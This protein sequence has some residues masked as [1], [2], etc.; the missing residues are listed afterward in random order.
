MRWAGILRNNTL[1]RI[2]LT[3]ERLFAN[4]IIQFGD[5]YDHMK[6]IA[7]N[8]IDTVLTDP[9]YGMDFQSKR[10]KNGPRYEKIV[11]DDK[12]DPL[13]LKQAYRVTK[14]GG[15]LIM[16]CD[17][18]TSDEWK[19]HIE[20]CGYVMKSQVIWNRMHHGTGDLHGSFAP[21]HDIIWYATKGRRIFY[22]S[23][24]YDTRPKSVLSHKRPSPS[25][26]NGHPTCKPV[27]LL[28]ELIK[29]TDDGSDGVILDP[30]LGSG[31]TAVACIKERKRFIGI[32]IDKKYHDIAVKRTIAEYKELGDGLWSKL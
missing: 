29:G 6:P 14:L 21:M 28:R 4:N 23:S 8:T 25:E 2:S 20:K 17:W 15:A 7:N 31:S 5:C 18:K 19:Y 3:I 27:E 10:S 13:W 22:K 32:E 11:S 16:F 12:V 30:F 1:W 24:A 9:P 26:D